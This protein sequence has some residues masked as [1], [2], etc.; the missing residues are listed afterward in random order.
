MKPYPLITRDPITDEELVVTRIEN[1]TRGLVLQGEFRFGWIARLTAEQLEFAGL[2]LRY[3]G[4]VQKLADA[5]GV[6]Y[7]TARSRL[8]GIVEALGGGE[9]EP[10]ASAPSSDAGDD[11]LSRLER[12]EIDFDVAMALLK[13]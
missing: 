3:R 12:G 11:V 7:N 5:L 2:L 13:R 6:S 10:S 9:A 8:D 4:N 1:K